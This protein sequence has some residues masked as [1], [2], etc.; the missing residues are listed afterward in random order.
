MSKYISI[1]SSGVVYSLTN[2]QPEMV[3]LEDIA[4]HLSGEC[5]YA[6]ATRFHYPV[7]E[8]SVLLSQVVPPRLKRVALMHDVAET[9]T[10]DIP[11]PHKDDNEKAKELDVEI[12]GITFDLYGLDIDLLDELHDYDK[13]ICVDEMTQLMPFVDPAIMHLEPLG[14]KIIERTRKQY[15]QRFL[16]TFAKLF[17][18]F[19]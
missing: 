15:K 14:V 5:R 3:N 12:T 18:E 13:R 8:H 19:A 9:W 2:F 6:N 16:D 7:S 4:H 11:C 1:S 17:P 10:K